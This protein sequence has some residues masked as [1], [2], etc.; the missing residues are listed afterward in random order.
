MTTMFAMYQVVR[1]IRDVPEQGVVQGMIGA[2]IEIF[3]GPVLT[4]EIEVVDGEGKTIVQATLTEND[5]EVVSSD[6]SSPT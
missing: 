5:L 6:P 4:Y 1:I 3:D 2:V